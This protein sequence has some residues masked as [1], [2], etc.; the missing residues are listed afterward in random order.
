[1]GGFIQY[2]GV[3]SKRVWK[4]IPALQLEMLLLGL[5][6]GA[7][8]LL[9]LKNG[10]HA[11]EQAR[12]EVGVTGNTDDTYLDF[13]IQ[14]IQSLD[15]SRLMVDFQTLSEEEAH[16]ALEDH[17]LS[18][19]I[20]VPDGLV[21]S[22]VY[23]RNDRRVEIVTA[24]ADGIFASLA[25]ELADIVST[26]CQ[27]SQSAVFGMQG[28]LY[29]QGMADRVG[30]CTDALDLRF[31][32][33]VLDRTELCGQEV[34]GIWDGI[35][36]IGYYLCGL[37]VFFLTLSGIAGSPLFAHRNRELCG[38]LA[39]RGLGAFGQVLGEYLAYAAVDLLF[40]AEETAALLILQR[41][42]VV[43][44]GEWKDLGAMGPMELGR[45]LLPVS[46]MLSAMQFLLYELVSG[47]VS[48]VLLQF[49]CSIVMGYLAG[50]FYP[51]PFFPDILQKLGGCL[52]VGEAVRYVQSG[53]AGD[54]SVTAFCAVAIYLAVFLG[55]SVAARKWKTERGR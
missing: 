46:L 14:T 47:T 29:R 16:R 11:K 5:C 44:I 52:P 27:S 35:S 15:P 37:S 21:E 9:F 8:A 4:L 20:R 18:C 48:C 12:F 24:N 38:M 23:G 7:G 54:A 33:V 17:K 40:L 30:G 2:I 3:Q 31:F 39:S 51:Y 41:T 55:L 53:V 34:L 26:L 6:L 42:G 19:Y 50:C 43:E 22:L 10:E 25:A 28:V 13:G 49:L 1:M 36:T 45:L 32:E